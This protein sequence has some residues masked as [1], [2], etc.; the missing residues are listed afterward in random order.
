MKYSQTYMSETQFSE[1]I[2]LWYYCKINN[3]DFFKIIKNRKNI[4][5]FPDFIIDD[6]TYLE[7]ARVS[8]EV[9]AKQE[10]DVQIVFS[11]NDKENKV[12]EMNTKLLKDYKDSHNIYFKEIDGV[13]YAFKSISTNDISNSLFK[14]RIVEKYKKYTEN[15]KNIKENHKLDLF[16]VSH[17]TLKD[18]KICHLYEWYKNDKSSLYFDNVYLL[19]LNEL[20]NILIMNRNRFEIIE[21]IKKDYKDEDIF[22]LI[23]NLK[24]LKEDKFIIK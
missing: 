9:M 10:K 18:E 5:N 6:D 12:G 11:S 16:L 15:S 4:N 22:K 20:N 1:A 8:N 21:G 2:A 23:C 13:V 24:W 19:Y 3:L 14:Q 17:L 7:V